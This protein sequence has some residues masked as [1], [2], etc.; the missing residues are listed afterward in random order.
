MK[1]ELGTMT[2]T[3]H[4]AIT[5]KNPYALAGHDCCRWHQKM[6]V[7]YQVNPPIGRSRG[8]GRLQRLNAPPNQGDSK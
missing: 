6:P 3:E 8:H 4:Y 1:T 2:I 7:E 5:T